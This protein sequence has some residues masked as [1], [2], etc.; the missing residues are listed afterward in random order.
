MAPK[1]FSAQADPARRRS[2]RL[3]AKVD[4]PELAD[5]A[6]LEAEPSRSR[7]AD[8][9]PAKRRKTTTTV[10]RTA[11]PKKTTRSGRRSLSK[12]PDMPLDI[13]FEIFGHLNPIDVLHLARTTKALRDILMRRSALSI[14]REARAHVD[15][16][17]DCPADLSEPQYANLLFDPHCHFCL[18][19]RVQNVMWN[20][21]LRCCKQCLDSNFIDLRTMFFSLPVSGVRPGAMLPAQEVKNKLLF[22]KARVTELDECMKDI[23]HDDEKMKKLEE[24]RIQAVMEMEAHAELLEEWHNNQSIQRMLEREHIRFKRRNSIVNRLAELGLAEEFLSMSDAMLRAFVDH[25]SVK[26]PKDLT[27]RIWNN[28]KD[29]IIEMM[30]NARATRL[31]KERC[32]RISTRLPLVCDVILGFIKSRPMDEYLP[33]VADFCAMPEV[34]DILALPIDVEVTEGTLAPVEAKF[35]ELVTRWR[36]DM[37]QRVLALMPPGAADDRVTGLARLD[38]ATTWFRCGKCDALPIGYPRVM[39]HECTAQVHDD[40]LD[41]VSEAPEAELRN[42]LKLTLDELPWSSEAAGLVFDEEVSRRARMLIKTCGKDPDVTT[43]REM[44][45]LD[46]RFVSADCATRGLDS[47]SVMTW[48]AALWPSHSESSGW[49]FLNETDTD[50]LKRMEKVDAEH[51]RDLCTSWVCERC[52]MIHESHEYMVS[53]FYAR[54]GIDIPV[55][56]RDYAPHLD[57]DFAPPG[58]FMHSYPVNIFTTPGITQ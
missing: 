49:L 15:G 11:A 58:P 24:E 17:P 10:A 7:D 25:P 47:L 46:G 57:A 35:P 4:Q 12:L 6:E 27:D 2:A 8:Y 31:A 3:R 14:W 39:V 18:T 43:A 33:G 32:V 13:L 45:E 40:A 52:R 22:P 44:D 34:L 38:L 23:I 26:Q 29:S 21:R 37:M 19:A 36:A 55:E 53:H 1:Q 41:V 20:C 48:R 42:A 30:L 9:V 51:D 56:G 54:H 28:I 50:R 16:L 5:D